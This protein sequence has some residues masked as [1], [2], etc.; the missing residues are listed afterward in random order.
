MGKRQLL[1]MILVLACFL[2]ALAY[3][4]SKSVIHKEKAKVEKQPKEISLPV[5]VTKEVAPKPEKKVVVVPAKEAQEK[6]EIMALIKN[7]ENPDWKI[8]QASLDK[9]AVFGKR[10]VPL[11]RD[12]LKGAS[13]GLKGQI[14]FLLGRIGDKEAVPELVEETKD[15][16]AYIRANA[17]EALGKINDKQAIPDVT[18]TLFDDDAVVR[19]RSAAALGQLN[20]PKTVGILLNRMT[21]EKNY[22]VKTTVVETLGELKDESAT[23]LLLQELSSRA[24]QTYKNTVVFSLGEIADPKALPALTE[25]LDKLKQYQPTEVMLTFELDEAIRIAEEAIAKIQNRNK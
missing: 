15:E 2:S 3:F 22:T 20:D 21:D 25:Y 18:K 7:L 10:A 6:E 4:V 12:S 13:L 17:V 16:N 14:T 5:S 9:L 23:T 11:L 19:Q 1:V 24:N 8:V